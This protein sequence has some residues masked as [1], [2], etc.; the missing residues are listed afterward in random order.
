MWFST[1]YF[2]YRSFQHRLRGAN[3]YCDGQ[4]HENGAENLGKYNVYDMIAPNFRKII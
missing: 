3:E 1:F 4:T 2:I